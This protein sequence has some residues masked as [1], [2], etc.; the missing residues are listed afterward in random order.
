MKYQGV[1]IGRVVTRVEVG[2]WRV[3]VRVEVGGWRVV[4]RVEVGGWR[5]V[6]RVEGAV[7]EAHTCWL[8]LTADTE[9]SL[10]CQCE[11]VR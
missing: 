8:S 6:T 10:L 5:V 9:Q 3:V 1:E 11:G 2:G 7:V 4:V